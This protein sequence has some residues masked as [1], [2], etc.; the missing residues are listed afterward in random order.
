MLTKSDQ[1]DFRTE[2]GGEELC[3]IAFKYVLVDF[4]NPK[5]TMDSSATQGLYSSL[6]DEW[7]TDDFLFL[8]NTHKICAVSHFT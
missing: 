1:T 8:H 7:G 6:T 4:M 3:D 5:A 2:G